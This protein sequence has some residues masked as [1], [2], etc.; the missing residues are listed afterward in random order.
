MLLNFFCMLFVLFAY[1]SQASSLCLEMVYLFY[2]FKSSS[3]PLPL[4]YCFYH[5]IPGGLNAAAYVIEWKISNTPSARGFACF[6]RLPNCGMSLPLYFRF[7]FLAP[8]FVLFNVYD[9]HTDAITFPNYT[10]T[11]AHEASIDRKNAPERV[12]NDD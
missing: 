8:L 9:W 3:A 7:L 2:F 5:T 12:E 1:I 11:C 6:A 10:C 4:L